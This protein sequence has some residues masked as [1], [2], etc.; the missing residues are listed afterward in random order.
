MKKLFTLALCAECVTF[1]NSFIF[2]TTSISTSVHLSLAN[3]L[4]FAQSITSASEAF[5]T[6]KPKPGYVGAYPSGGL[7]LDAGVSDVI[8][9]SFPSLFLEASPYF[10]TTNIPTNTF[11][12][13][14]PL[15]GKIASVKRIVGPK[16]S[17]EI[18]HI[19]IGLFTYELQRC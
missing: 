14:E 10:D 13:K 18:C 17:G 1:A 15:L 11:K 8:Q 2:K 9:D 3:D 4:D 7:Q 5:A 16:A 12:A 6:M 19:T